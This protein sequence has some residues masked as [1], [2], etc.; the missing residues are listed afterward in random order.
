MDFL[1]KISGVPVF[2]PDF[3]VMGQQPKI[4]EIARFGEKNF[5]SALSIFAGSDP[6]FYKEKVL[7]SAPEEEKGMLRVELDYS[8]TSSFTVFSRYCQKQMERLLVESLLYLFFPTLRKVAWVPITE[9]KIM[10]QLSF[11]TDEN[12][13]RIITLDEKNFDSLKDFIK[14][15]TSFESEDQQEA[16]IKPA[17]KL[18]QAIADKMADAAE[19]R[20]RIYGTNSSK[21]EE[22]LIGTMCSILATADGIPVTEVLNMTFLQVLI[23]VNRTQLFQQYRTQIT[24]GAFGG[25]DADDVVNWQKVL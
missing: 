16:G 23:Q 1:T 18:A 13:L 20:A 15:C 4:Q 19:R 6:D 12:E 9:T 5:F 14:D 21:K 10:T 22:S 11:A 7:E 17:G 3:N 8:I 24:L 25:L 2:L